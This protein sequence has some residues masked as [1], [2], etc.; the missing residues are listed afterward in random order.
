MDSPKRRKTE[1][2]G[3]LVKLL[4]LIVKFGGLVHQLF[5]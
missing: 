3:Q 4:T 1:L 2:L 5:R